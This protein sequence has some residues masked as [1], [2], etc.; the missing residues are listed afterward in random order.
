MAKKLSE[1]LTETVSVADRT[2]RDLHV[3]VLAKKGKP[4]VLR[5]VARRYRLLADDIDRFADELNE[6][7]KPQDDSPPWKEDDDET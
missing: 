4:T 1:R 6:L 2:T 3:M 7:G 5:D